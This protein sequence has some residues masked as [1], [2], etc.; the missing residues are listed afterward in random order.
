MAACVRQVRKSWELEHQKDSFFWFV[1]PSTG[2]ALSPPLSRISSSSSSSSSWSLSRR[3]GSPTRL[4]SNRSS[5]AFSCLF[6][7]CLGR[8]VLRTREWVLVCG[9]A[10]KSAIFSDANAPPKGTSKRHA[11]MHPRRFAYGGLN[12]KAA[13]AF[14]RSKQRTRRVTKGVGLSGSNKSVSRG[15]NCC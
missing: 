12:A 15:R 11:H 9:A 2:L 8:C 6:S 7:G 4:V 10:E 5:H 13:K 3:T 14:A 1:V